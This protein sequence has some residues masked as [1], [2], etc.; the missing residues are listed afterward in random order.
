[1]IIPAYLPYYVVAGTTG[2]IA[3]ILIGLSSA[4]PA[5]RQRPAARPSGLA[6]FGCWLRLVCS[7]VR[8]QLPASC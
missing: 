1:M 6:S 7:S 2:I 5:R 3:T 8:I 4:L